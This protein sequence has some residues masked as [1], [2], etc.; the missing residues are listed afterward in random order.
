MFA[1]RNLSLTDHI[2]LGAG[3]GLGLLFLPGMSLITHWFRR[4]RALALGIAVSGASV[5][6]MLLPIMLNQLFHKP[7][8]GFAWGVRAEAFLILAL[9]IIVNL[10]MKT[11][12]PSGKKAREAAAMRKKQLDI[13]SIFRDGPYWVAVAGSVF[14]GYL[15]S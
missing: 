15:E 8:V 13:K 3:I 11:R 12:L 9:L 2:G 5:G 7:S 10:I 14:I 6:R 4:G 1:H